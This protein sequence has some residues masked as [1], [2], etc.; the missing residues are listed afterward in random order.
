MYRSTEKRKKDSW[1][2]PS[3]CF[4]QIVGIKELTY[5]SL[6]SLRIA[7][8]ELRNVG[9]DWLLVR[10][11]HVNVLRVQKPG[12]SQFSVRNLNKNTHWVNGKK[13]F[14]DW[15]WRQF[16]V[17]W[18]WSG[19]AW[20]RDRRCLGKEIDRQEKMLR[21]Q[22]TV[23]GTKMCLIWQKC[24]ASCYKTTIIPPKSM[25]H[26]T[27]IQR[28]VWLMVGGMLPSWKELKKRYYQI[29]IMCDIF[30]IGDDV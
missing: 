23:R 20:L 4:M 16:R 2:E 3:Q 11:L 8:K 30:S 27:M 10:T 19:V 22:E 29:N 28:R 12:D 7:V 6:G 18:S 17:E 21:R 13:E 26:K 24:R 25:S 14:C 5:P 9:H 15:P 1:R